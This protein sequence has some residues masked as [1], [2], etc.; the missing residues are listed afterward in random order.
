MGL[1]RAPENRLR[2]GGFLTAFSPL[3]VFGG[4]SNLFVIGITWSESP[5]H[6]EHSTNLGTPGCSPSVALTKETAN[7]LLPSSSAINYQDENR[8][9]G[10]TWG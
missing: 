4:S 10:I 3:V 2:L 6:A 8:H 7:S 9:I 5:L 1:I